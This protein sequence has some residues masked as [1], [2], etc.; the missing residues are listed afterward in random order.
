MGYNVGLLP[1]RIYLIQYFY[2]G[3]I[4]GEC[5]LCNLGSKGC[6]FMSYR[7]RCIQHESY[8]SVG[9]L[10]L[11]TDSTE[12]LITLVGQVDQYLLLP[13]GFLGCLNHLDS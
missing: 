6:R 9:C 5:D 10:L 3:V 1:E 2:G 13:V 4:D 8:V 11:G 12:D 7:L